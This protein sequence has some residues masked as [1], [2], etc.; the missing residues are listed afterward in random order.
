MGKSQMVQQYQNLNLIYHYIWISNYY[1]KSSHIA[2]KAS[3]FRS[4]SWART[5]DPLINSQML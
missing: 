2:V 3:N 4:S 5:K 1:K